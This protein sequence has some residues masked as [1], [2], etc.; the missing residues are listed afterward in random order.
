M[1][2]FCDIKRIRCI[3]T[4]RFVLC[5]CVLR[6]HLR[7]RLLMRLRFTETFCKLL[8]IVLNL[9]CFVLQYLMLLFNV[10]L[11]KKLPRSI[12]SRN[13]PSIDIVITDNAF[14]MLASFQT[15]YQD[16]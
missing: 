5:G 13:I 7:L 15:S 10:F 14:L 4:L 1:K 12:V 8:K 2:D 9:N 11:M 3:C 6:F 16:A